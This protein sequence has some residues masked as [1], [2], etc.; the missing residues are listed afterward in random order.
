M[1]N[2]TELDTL[3]SLARRFKRY[4]LSV[5][6]LK[7]EADAGRLPCLKA[8]RRLLFDPAAVEAELL[9]RAAQKAVARA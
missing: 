5:V 4:G 8:G 9:R 1:I 6:W 2:A 3:R 7:A